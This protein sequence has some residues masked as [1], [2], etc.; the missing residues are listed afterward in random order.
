MF[1]NFSGFLVS[2]ASERDIEFA[3]RHPAA[4]NMDVVILFSELVASAGTRWQS[5]YEQKGVWLVS[6]LP[7]LLK[8]ESFA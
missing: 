8:L 6:C 3:S 7:I 2:G 5:N 4:Q 1:I